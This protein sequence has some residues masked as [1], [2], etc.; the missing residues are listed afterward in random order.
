LTGF[1]GGNRLARDAS[2][3]GELLLRESGG[4]ASLSQMVFEHRLCAIFAFLGC[5]HNI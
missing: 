1:Y 2:H 5:S 4:L 3:I